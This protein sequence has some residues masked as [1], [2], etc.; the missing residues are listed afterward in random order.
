[1]SVRAATKDDVDQ[2][3]NCNLSAKTQKELKGFAPPIGISKYHDS[4]L[5]KGAWRYPNIVE[6]EEIYVCLHTDKI[7]GYAFV[8]FDQDYLELDNMD[9]CG[10]FQGKGFGKELVEWIE[11][12]ARSRGKS[13]VTLG[14][15]RSSDDTPWKSYSFWIKMG[16]RVSG[17]IRTS[18]GIRYGFT[19][20]RFE[21][22]I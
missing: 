15:T 20:I 12:F 2:I 3:V 5:L 21:K 19:G 4:R 10:K 11:N 16:Y 18:A 13:R 9:I 14:T 6:G 22:L 17:E 1:M 8:I 7:V